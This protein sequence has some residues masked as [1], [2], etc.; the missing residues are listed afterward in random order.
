MQD[1]EGNIHIVSVGLPKSLAD[2]L[3]TWTRDQGIQSLKI[4]KKPAKQLRKEASEKDD[5]DSKKQKKAT[6]PSQFTS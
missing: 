4:P 6:A 5:K 2:E 3:E 1:K